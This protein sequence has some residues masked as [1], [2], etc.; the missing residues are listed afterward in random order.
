MRALILLTAI[1]LFG[2][3]DGLTVPTVDMASDL[4]SASDFA[5]ECHEGRACNVNSLPGQ[6]GGCEPTVCAYSCMTL[7]AGGNTG[8]CV[9]A[10]P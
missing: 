9:L 8:I 7:P 5:S 10:G 6:D 3:H 2:C 1:S 4:T